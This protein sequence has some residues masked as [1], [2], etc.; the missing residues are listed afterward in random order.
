MEPA[1]LATRVE[2]LGL[3]DAA[4]RALRKNGIRTVSDIVR[5]KETEFW[6][7]RGVGP[8]IAD[9]VTR[10]LRSAGLHFGMTD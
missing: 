9:E 1:I 3:T 6:D 8:V 10:L 7:L 2:S 5:M 4:L